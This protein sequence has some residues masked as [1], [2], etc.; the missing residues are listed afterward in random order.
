VEDFLAEELLVFRSEW[1]ARY[2]VEKQETK[3]EDFISSISTKVAL[4]LLMY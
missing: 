2:E 1:K 3:L 4:H